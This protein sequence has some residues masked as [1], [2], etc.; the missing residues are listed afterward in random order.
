MK[1]TI[2]VGGRFHA[3]HLAKQLQERGCLTKLFTSRPR[4][5]VK[6]SG[7][8]P[9]K[10]GCLPLKEILERSLAKVPYLSDALGISYYTANLFDKQVARQIRPCDIFVGWSGFSLYTLRKIRK[11]FPAKI[12]LE[13][14][15]SHLQAQCDVSTSEQE[16][17][18]SKVSQPPANF[19][20]KELKEYAETDYIIVPSTLAR[21]SFLDKGFPEEKIICVPSGVDTKRF[22]PMPKN[23][24]VFRIICVG[25]SVLK[26]T[27]YLLQAIDELKIKGLELMLVGRVDNDIKPFLRRYSGIFR[28]LG[29]IPQ[30]ELYKYYS[31][32]SCSILF[33]LDDGFGW[34]ILEAMS[35]GI[36]VISSDKAG[37]KDVIREGVDGFIVPDRDVQVL[38]EKILYLY[39]NPQI[40][41]EMGR[42]AYENV[43]NNFTWDHYGKKIMDIYSKLLD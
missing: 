18:G 36:T 35:C 32:A 13:H 41:Q 19:V 29:G 11:A 38:K 8:P 27:H 42:R 3:F 25:I 39:M 34:A 6:E 16:R 12:I 33:S 15:S 43:T 17:L 26:G 40:C 31:Q 23:D 5:S 28:Y 1:V 24:G 7:I 22:I 21:K 30:K 14:T 20:K 37:V 10:I 9:E 2:S 4:F